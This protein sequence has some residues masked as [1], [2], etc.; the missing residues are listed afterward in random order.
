MK[1]FTEDDERPSIPKYIPSWE[2]HHSDIF[3]KYPI[4]MI[5][6]HPRYTMHT[7]TDAKDSFTNDITDHRVLIDGYYYWIARVNS[8][9]AE[10]R[11]IKNNDLI[12]LYN[13]RGSVICAAQVGERT[14]PGIIHSYEACA[15]YDPIGTPGA[16]DSIDKSGCV[17]ILSPKRT[18]TRTANGM[19][20]NSCL[21]EFEKWEGSL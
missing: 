2:G 18:T 16:S 14:P 20:N 5:M 15:D 17:N 21:V 13:D 3:K 8:V 9:D 1:R 10:A 12:R 4:A 11:G 6:P 19:A 7:S